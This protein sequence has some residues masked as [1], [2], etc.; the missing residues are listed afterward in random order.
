MCEVELHLKSKIDYSVT[1]LG[2]W[3]A[4]GHDRAE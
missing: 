4:A 1:I 3:Q 2:W